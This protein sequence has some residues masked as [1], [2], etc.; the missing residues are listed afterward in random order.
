M[1]KRRG[2]T[3]VERLENSLFTMENGER[4]EPGAGARRANV[5]GGDETLSLYKTP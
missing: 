5:P 2:P 3:R 4:I 1:G